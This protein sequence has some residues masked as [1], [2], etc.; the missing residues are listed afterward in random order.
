[1]HIYIYMIYMVR[2]PTIWWWARDGEND[3]QTSNCG[4][5]YF[6]GKL[7]WPTWATVPQVTQWIVNW[8]VVNSKY[9]LILSY[10]NSYRT[11]T[12]DVW[13]SRI[14]VKTSIYWPSQ[15]KN[16]R[17]PGNIFQVENI[18]MYWG[19]W[20]HLDTKVNIP[21]IFCVLHGAWLALGAAKCL[22]TKVGFQCAIHALNV[23]ASQTQLIDSPC[24]H[25]VAY[26]LHTYYIL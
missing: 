1:M 16:P 4:A 15:K 20:L 23:C 7:T 13:K 3:D 12:C 21:V 2:Y 24:I 18:T 25:R 5:P 19:P 26:C 10:S 14:M 8:L 22:S 6:L 17:D 9:V 11:A